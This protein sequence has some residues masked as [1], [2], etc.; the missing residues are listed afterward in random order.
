MP[1]TNG[2]RAP[3]SVARTMHRLE[4]EE[5]RTVS[6]LLVAM[7]E[8]RGED[9]TLLADQV[10]R[11]AGVKRLLVAHRADKPVPQPPRTQ[12]DRFLI[13]SYALH[14]LHAYLTRGQT[15]WMAAITGPKLDGVRFLS[16]L[17]ELPADKLSVHG[18]TANDDGVFA[19][20][21]TLD[22]FGHGLHA[23]VH[24]HRFCGPPRPSDVDLRMQEML[25]AGKYAAIQGICSEDGYFRFFAGARDF[26]VEVYG[27]NVEQIDEKLFRVR[28]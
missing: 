23:L 13:G 15:E 7:T 14:Q 25:D 4:G 6:A 2:H 8:G 1:N 3:P 22:R 9:V 11:L 19:V 16:D 12:V 26:T 28:S 24:S 5:D 17:V 20:L 27:S 18:V 10:S 21:C